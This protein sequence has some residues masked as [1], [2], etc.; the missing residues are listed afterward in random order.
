MKALFANR[1]FRIVAFADLL[2]QLA[3]WVRNI[4]LLFYVMEQTNNDPV[5][6]SLLNVM[7]YAPIFLFSFIGGAFADRW[8]P[9]RTMIAGDLLSA[10]SIGAILFF[11]LAGTWQAVFAATVVSAIVSQFS[12]PSSAVMFKRHVPEELL[13]PAISISQGIMSLFIIVGPVIGTLIYSSLG[14]TFSLAVLIVLFLTAAAV[15]FF[16]PPSPRSPERSSPPILNDMKDGFRYIRSH[17]NLIIIAI[18]FACIGLGS[19]L[20]RPLDIYIVTERLQLD[21]ESVQW[22]YALSGAGMLIGGVAAAILGPKINPRVA[23][24]TGIAFLS[25]SMIVEAL[26]VWVYL[27]AAMRFMVGVMTAFMQIVLGAIMMK[28]VE[29]AYIGRVNGTITP[30]LMAGTLIGSAL[31]GPLMKSITLVPVYGLSAAI[32]LIAAFASLSMKFG[33]GSAAK[34]DQSGTHSA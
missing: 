12:Q 34:A 25:F 14:L 19:G 33:G 6:V 27:T 30:L 28:L 24:F 10:L 3:I 22:F 8:N 18:T 2:Q 20:V 17:R 31:A 29:E 15:Q 26:S 32:V 11:V 16:L 7:E 9:K 13:A 4:A 21:K 1:V 5:A 23:I